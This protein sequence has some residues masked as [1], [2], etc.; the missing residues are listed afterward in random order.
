MNSDKEL[1]KL[2]QKGDEAAFTE[3]INKYN[4]K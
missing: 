4:R 2:L 1:I 3:L